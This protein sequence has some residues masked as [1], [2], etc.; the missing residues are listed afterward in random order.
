M[1]QEAQ[2]QYDAWVREDEAKAQRAQKVLDD[3]EMFGA[4]ELQ[5]LEIR[6]QRELA[7]V[8]GH[9]S[10]QEAIRQKYGQLRNQS[11]LSQKARDIAIASGTFGALADVAMQGGG[12]LFSIGKRFAKTETLINAWA[13]ASHALR[14]PFPHSLYAF[15]QVLATGMKS[16][17]NIESASPGGGGSASTAFG[18]SSGGGGGVADFGSVPTSPPAITPAPT[19]RDNGSLAGQTGIVATF[20]VYGDALDAEQFAKRTAEKIA[21][22]SRFGQVPVQVEV[23]R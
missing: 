13:G 22:L 14:L 18:S 16:Y 9:E 15:A 6:Q 2:R 1:A 7:A 11:L 21:E 4:S 23:R 5:A 12:R 10:A 19:I 8:E 20:H 3:A 17:H